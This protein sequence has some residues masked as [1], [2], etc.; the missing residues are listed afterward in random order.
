M[1]EDGSDSEDGT[2]T[3][4]DDE[5]GW[6]YQRDY[7]PGGQFETE[8]TEL[9]YFTSTST[10]DVEVHAATLSAADR[11]RFISARDRA[12]RTILA[13]ELARAEGAVRSHE[14]VV[15]NLRAECIRARGGVT[16]ASELARAEDVLKAAKA[17]AADLRAR[18]L[19]G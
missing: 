1:S 4:S 16:R 5:E 10:N 15:E 13:S 8:L 17:K 12:A 19:H 2:S 6:N 9:L 11:A 3:L 14:A 18:W 7:F